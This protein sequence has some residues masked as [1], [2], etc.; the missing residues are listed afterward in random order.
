GGIGLWMSL[1]R[2]IQLLTV[3]GTTGTTNRGGLQGPETSLAVV[4][5]TKQPR[6]FNARDE[7]RSRRSPLN[8]VA[9]WLRLIIFLVFAASGMAVTQF[10]AH[11]FSIEKPVTQAQIYN[12]K[13]QAQYNE[14]QTHPK[15]FWRKAKDNLPAL[16]A[17]LGAVIT[18]SVAIVSMSFNYHATL[19]RQ[20]D[21]QFD[22]ALRRFGDRDNCIV[23]ASAAGLLA[24]MAQ[25]QPR[26]F[27]SA[28][29]QLFSG[30]MLERS[31]LT[32]DSIRTSILDLTSTNPVRALKVL[33]VLNTTFSRAVA[34]AFIGFCAV[35]GAEAIESVPD[36]LWKEAEII[37]SFDQRAI[38]ALFNTLPRGFY[39]RNYD[40]I[41]RKFNA[42]LAEELA[43]HK[44]ATCVELR[45]NAERLRTNIESIG[46]SCHLMNARLRRKIALHL[47]NKN[48][49]RAFPDTFLIGARLRDVQ[50][51]SLVGA[52]LREADLSGANLS[53]AKLSG[54]D[55]SRADLSDAKLLHADCRRARFVHAVLKGADLTR[56][57]FGSAELSYADLTD[58]KFRGTR[59]APEALEST[60]W[61]KAD[62]TEQPNLLKTVYKKYKKNLPDLETLYIKGQIHRSVLDFIGELKERPT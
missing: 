12:Q 58:T 62:F 22:E 27:Y 38:K 57:H 13:P 53:R 2:E 44:E 41:L 20:Q 17:I 60:E 24:G 31:S 1:I 56:A 59:I 18:A 43:A 30:L 8:R 51:W 10:C 25:R 49:T 32:L 35:H 47:F 14:K 55:L 52:V 26:Y 4:L 7:S 61:W 5:A 34:E 6:S 48:V 39:S 9:P 19:R 45:D 33:A 29:V 16:G 36:K 40:R 21:N 37:T 11:A 3:F 42:L 23:R 28:F 50:N 54:A 46:L 15:S